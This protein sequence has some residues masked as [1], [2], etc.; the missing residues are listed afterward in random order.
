ML[1][2]GLVLHVRN[3]SRHELSTQLTWKI[4][5]AIGCNYSLHTQTRKLRSRLLLSL[6]TAVFISLSFPFALAENARLQLMSTASTK[7]QSKTDALPEAEEHGMS[8]K[9]VEIA[10]P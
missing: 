10:R 1:L 2:P 9:A 7:Q 8:P 3:P 5:P 4:A 6:L